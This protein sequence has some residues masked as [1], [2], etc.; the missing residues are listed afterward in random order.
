MI[1]V[2]VLINPT[3]TLRYCKPDTV[4]WAI[5]LESSVLAHVTV[6]LCCVCETSVKTCPDVPEI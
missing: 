6:T 3:A 4:A 2:P 5:R 1:A